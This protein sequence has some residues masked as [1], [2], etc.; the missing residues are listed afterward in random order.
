MLASVLLYIR[1]AIARSG[2]RRILETIK[3]ERAV[4]DWRRGDSTL[5]TERR[6]DISRHLAER[7]S[8]AFVLLAYSSFIFG[9]ISMVMEWPRI[10][11]VPL[12]ALAIGLFVAAVAQSPSEDTKSG[13]VQVP[14][15]GRNAPC[16]CGSEKK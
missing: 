14:P 3:D 4:Q 9:A 7:R 16:P 11:T 12:M 5:F 8:L 1:F 2:W 13:F 15:T 10:L 6:I